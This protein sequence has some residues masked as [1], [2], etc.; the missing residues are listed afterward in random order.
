VIRRIVRDCDDWINEATR[1]AMNP[2]VRLRP[3]RA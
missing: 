2:I 1:S 3:A